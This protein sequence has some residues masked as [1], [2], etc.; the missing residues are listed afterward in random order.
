VPEVPAVPGAV[1]DRGRVA[2]AFAPTARSRARSP[3]SRRGRA[4]SRWPPRSPPPSPKAACCSPKPAPAPA[5]RWPTSCPAILSRQRVLVSTGTKNL[6]EQIYF[7]D[8]P[9]LA[10]RSASPSRATYMKGRGNYLC[11]HRFDAW[12]RRAPSPARGARGVAGA[13]SSTPGARAPTR[14]T[15]RARGPAGGPAA[16]GTTSPRRPRTASAPSAPSTPTAS[17]RACGSA[18]PNPTSSSSTTTCCAPMRR[19]GRAR[20]AR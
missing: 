6:Q 15:G 19:C 8:L 2:R 12:A 17:S 14:A 7:K 11:L 16:S 9:V 1:A 4:S 10:T 18:P 20:T 5:R 3:A 13:G